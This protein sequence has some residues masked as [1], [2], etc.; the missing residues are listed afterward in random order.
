MQEVH[1]V[2]TDS[3]E[4]PEPT[5]VLDVTVRAYGTQRG[6]LAE[7]VE[8]AIES[9]LRACGAGA[10]GI[11]FDVDRD[12]RLSDQLFRARRAGH[13]GITIRLTALRALCAPVGGL[14]AFDAQTIAFYASACSLRPVALVLDDAD[15]ELPAFLIAKPLSSLLES[16]SEPEPEPE[17][18]SVSL[19]TIIAESI[20]VPELESAIETE[21]ETEAEAE[22]EAETEAA[23]F[24]WEEHADAL[25]AA[26][27][28]QTLVAFERLFAEHYLP[29][30]NAIDRGLHAR[31]AVA[32]R[33]EFRRSFSRAYSEALPT[34]ALTGKRPRMVLDAFDVAS[35][36]ARTHN[37]RSVQILLVDG[38]RFDLASHICA[39]AAELLEGRA[40]LADLITL[41]S[42]L[43]S[44][45][46]RQL[47]T[48]ARG[49]EAL[50]S[51]HDDRETEPLRGRT[52]DAVRRVRLGSRDLYKLDLVETTLAT[53]GDAAI[54]AIDDLTEQTAAA[55]AKHARTQR[56]RTLLFVVGDH[57]FCFQGGATKHGGASPE[58][59]I[60]SGHA[61]LVSD[62][63]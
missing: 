48:L 55:I 8:E 2:Y 35:K 11:A 21:T 61:F 47:E 5:N 51:A 46:P 52:A 1:A 23:T 12:T 40:A 24:A 16:E 25:D 56:S 54:D 62:L 58:E 22:A 45:T 4:A 29:L 32:A 41:F 53:A 9:A 33:E 59:V 44:S 19:A 26:R 17:V 34:F 14:D 57:G 31:G 42:A 28:P 60:V 36:M 7:H 49:V 37:A 3:I 10:A 50:R 15:R 30:A 38:M 6:G 13:D 18:A 27:G 43:P 63:H 20:A 39:R